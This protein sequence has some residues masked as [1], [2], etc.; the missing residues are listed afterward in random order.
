MNTI[1]RFLNRI[2]FRRANR[3]DESKNV[4]DGM[5]RA[6]ILYK[7]LS[8]KAYPDRNPSK[9]DVAEDLFKRINANRF[10]YA[11]LLRLKQEVK[12]KLS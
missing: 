12:M 4:I 10:N 7:E 8:M 9:K 6:K 2:K 3:K 11:M 5:V 1:I